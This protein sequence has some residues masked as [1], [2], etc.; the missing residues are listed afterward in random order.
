MSEKNNELIIREIESEDNEK[1]ALLIREVLTE[2]GINRPGTV[3]TDPTTDNLFK[4]F[5]RDDAKYWVAESGI[6]L[7]GCCGYYPTEG[8]DPNCVELVKLYV[9]KDS[10]G[11]GLGKRLMETTIDSARDAGYESIY[12]E[13]LPELSNAVELYKNLGF[14]PLTSPLGNSGHFACNLWMLK[15]F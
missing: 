8:L 5:D 11:L 13:T 7:V 10:R 2:F 14:K 9:H 6:E 12:L 15:E 4:L 3:Y 1:L